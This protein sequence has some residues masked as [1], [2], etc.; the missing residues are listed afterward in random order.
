MR[1]GT[2]ATCARSTASRGTTSIANPC[3]EHPSP[4]RRPVGGGPRGGH[5]RR[6]LSPRNRAHDDN[7]WPSARG[8]DSPHQLGTHAPSGRVWVSADPALGSAH[9]GRW[10]HSGTVGLDRQRLRRGLGFWA[11]YPGV[12]AGAHELPTT[13]S[14]RMRRRP[15]PRQW[16]VGAPPV[17]VRAAGSG[18]ESAMQ[19]HDPRPAEK[20]AMER[21]MGQPPPRRLAGQM[22]QPQSPSVTPRRPRCRSDG[23]LVSSATEGP[24]AEEPVRAGAV[25]R[26][27]SPHRAPPT[28][29][30]SRS[31]RE[32]SLMSHPAGAGTASSPAGAQHR[33]RF[34]P[35][36]RRSPRRYDY[37][38]G[39]LPLPRGTAV[40]PDSTGH[41]WAVVPCAR[42]VVVWH[43]G[44]PTQRNAAPA[45]D[46]RRTRA[47]PVRLVGCAAGHA[48]RSSP[49]T[50]ELS[51]HRN[52]AQRAHPVRVAPG[53][54]PCTRATLTDSRPAVSPGCPTQHGR[55]RPTR[56]RRLPPRERCSRARR[57]PSRL[58]RAELALL[59]EGRPLPGVPVR[60]VGTAAAG[61]EGQRRRAGNAAAGGPRG[62]RS[63]AELLSNS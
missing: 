4:T 26:G 31:P 63:F 61:A 32:T 21:R 55:D 45:R 5:L 17:G 62:Q 28:G 9:Y 25:A 10:D 6:E 15:P 49:A 39:R 20:M 44:R 1:P 58:P 13:L 30:P 51:M 46:R 56:G 40:T 43:A 27:A 24:C 52:V 47:P 12:L 16:R 2:R 19:R 36:D 50:S 11:Y 22:K 29:E 57:V 42:R 53:S 3:Q 8:R 23:E 54:R 59:P 7:R 41:R 60:R 48:S 34:T 35:G 37:E 14:L 18:R 33:D 38:A